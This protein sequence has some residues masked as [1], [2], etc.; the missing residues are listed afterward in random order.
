[1]KDIEVGKKFD[2]GEIVLSEQ[3]II[4]FAKAFDPLDFHTDPE[5]AKQT[6]FKG[7][8]ASGPHI[9]NLIYRREWVPRFGKTVI[10]G[11][12]VSNWKFIKPVYANQKI[13]VELS[14]LTIVPDPK[15]GGTSISWL[16]EFKNE[17]GEMVQLLQMDVMHKS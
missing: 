6:I 11:T 16:F 2:L 5:V 13:L 10:C 9:F 4:D 3:N 12:G 17:K 7:L 14:V 15:I 1:M 8:I